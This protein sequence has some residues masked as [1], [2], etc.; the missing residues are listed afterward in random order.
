MGEPNGNGHN[1]TPEERAGILVWHLA[2][3]D[4]L[5]TEDAARLTGLTHRGALRLLC[6]LSRVLPI[7]QD[8]RALWQVLAMREAE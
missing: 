8:D 1:K 4:A 7:Y 2:H 6:G 3:G 5:L